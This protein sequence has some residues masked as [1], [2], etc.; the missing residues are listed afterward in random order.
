[1]PSLV[2]SEMCI[3]DRYDIDEYLYKRCGTPG[4][5]APEVINA[6]SNQNIHYDPKCD[7][8]SAGVIFYILLTE[9]S[10]FDG[11]SFKEILQKNK[12]CNIDFDIKALNSNSPAV[13]LLRKML[14]KDPV[15]RLSAKQALKHPFFSLYSIQ[16]PEPAKT[17]AVL[18]ENGNKFQEMIQ[19]QKKMVMENNQD[20]SSLIVR[21][22]IINGCL[23]YTSPSPRD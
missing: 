11:R 1:M 14:T 8:F 9:K 2:G 21:K 16:N 20:G 12:K 10:P 3:R 15:K 23:L 6:P 4:F 18:H 17:E 13:D 22:Q 19:K 7:V 5:V